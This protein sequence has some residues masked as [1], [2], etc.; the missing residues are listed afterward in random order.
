MCGRCARVTPSDQQR[1][2]PRIPADC[3]PI[4]ALELKMIG[5]KGPEQATAGKGG[6]GS[7]KTVPNTL[8]QQVKYASCNKLRTDGPFWATADPLWGF[9]WPVCTLSTLST[10]ARFASPEPCSGPHGD[11]SLDVAASWAPWPGLQF[12]RRFAVAHTLHVWWLA[13]PG[14]GPN[15]PPDPSVGPRVAVLGAVRGRGPGGHGR[16]GGGRKVT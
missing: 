2:S 1:S 6:P 7:P 15:A 11:G 16:V 12:P 9:L 14:N 13:P 4:A 3:N 8:T 10:L 5:P